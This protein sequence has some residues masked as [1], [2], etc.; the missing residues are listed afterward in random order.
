MNGEQ[1][2]HVVRWFLTAMSG[3]VVGGLSAR[4]VLT[5]D[6]LDQVSSFIT[7]ETMVALIIAI[8][9]LVWGL[10]SH[11]TSSLIGKAA[12]L[13]EVE[14]VELVPNKESVK[15]L[16]KVGSSPEARVTIAPF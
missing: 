7:S 2:N 16:D 11:S 3:V 1:T 8:I 14:N 6:Q 9:P 5:A 13:K 4:H 12:K 15:I 10:I